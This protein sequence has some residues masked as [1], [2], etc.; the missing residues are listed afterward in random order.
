MAR[1][2]RDQETEA[3]FH[4]LLYMI[5]YHIP[6]LSLSLS[7]GWRHLLRHPAAICGV[8]IPTNRGMLLEGR[9]DIQGDSSILAPEK[10]I[11]LGIGAPPPSVGKVSHIFPFFFTTSGMQDWL[12]ALKLRSS[13]Q[14]DHISPPPYCKICF[15]T[16][17]SFW[18]AKNNLV[19]RHQEV[20]LGQ[21]PPPP[22]WEF[23]PHNPVFF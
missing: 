19:S 17:E 9:G 18:H 1:C 15:S 21:T 8:K 12:G 11:A 5:V 6:S 7:Y 3:K 2:V 4:D 10:T 16:S 14:I 23:F 20:G 13:A 22:V